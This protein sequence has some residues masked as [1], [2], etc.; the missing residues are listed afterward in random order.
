[1]SHHFIVM[2]LEWNQRPSYRPAAED[3]LPFEIIEIGAVKLDDNLQIVSEFQRLIF[4]HVY[5]KLHKKIAEVTH[6]TMDELCAK[7]EDFLD[8]MEEFL[9]WC[10][11]DY[12]FCTWGSMDLTELQR[13]MVYHGME[14]PFP[15]PVLYYD[16]QKIYGLIRG[17]KAA[18]SLDTVVGELEIPIDENRPFHR[19]EDDAWYTALVMQ[20]MGFYNKENYISVDYYQLPDEEDEAFLLHFPDYDKMVTHPY[21][22]REEALADRHLTQLVCCKCQ[23]ALRKKIR[24]FSTNQRYYYCLATCPEHGYV[25]GKIRIKKSDDGFYFAVKTTKLTD[26]QGVDVIVGK[27]DD[28]RKKR[29]ERSRRVRQAAAQARKNAGQLTRRKILEK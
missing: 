21:E 16:L 1:M 29:A 15:V 12:T 18:E 19:A 25:K 17:D 10:G 27:K 22:S 9:A 13:N 28:I 7:G 3:C 6:L 23:R 24:G 4:P 8:V 2:D 26:Q 5:R 14:L 11:D 20:K